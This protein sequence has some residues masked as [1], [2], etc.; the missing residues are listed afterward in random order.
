MRISSYQ[1]GMVLSCCPASMRAIA[2]SPRCRNRAPLPG[3]RPTDRSPPPSRRLA[4]AGSRASIPSLSHRCRTRRSARTIGRRATTGGGDDRRSAR[5]D[6]TPLIVT[7]GWPGSIAEF[8]DVIE[9][10][11]DPADADAPSFHVVASSARGPGRRAGRQS[12]TLPY[13]QSAGD[14]PS[15]HG[16][17]S[18]SRRRSDGT[19]SSARATM[20]ATMAAPR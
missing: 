1:Y 3:F 9:E 18:T 14:F 10:L 5:A 15:A 13:W 12:V 17:S 19:T 7:H 8:V 20:P 16:V 4:C 6:A 2:S 11:A